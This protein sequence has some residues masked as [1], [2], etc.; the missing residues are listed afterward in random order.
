MAVDPIFVD[1]NVPTG[2]KN[3]RDAQTVGIE[4]FG[5]APVFH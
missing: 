2:T 3:I 4:G 1:T 5:G